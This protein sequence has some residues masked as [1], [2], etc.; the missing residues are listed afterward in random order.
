MTKW[1]GRHNIQESGN[2]R[3]NRR[4]QHNNYNNTATCGDRN[5][6]NKQGMDM[7]DIDCS[8]NNSDSCPFAQKEKVI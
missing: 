2:I 7:V 8:D 5:R 1:K 3:R 4:N 6:T